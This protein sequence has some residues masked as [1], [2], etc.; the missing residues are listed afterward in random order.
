MSSNASLNFL[1]GAAS[2]I[3]N[4][5]WLASVNGVTIFLGVLLSAMV[6]NTHNRCDE[7][8]FN[9]DNMVYFQYVVAIILLV[10]FLL[11]FVIDMAAVV[12]RG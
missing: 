7:P 1:G 11:L 4:Y 12:R 3:R 10:V 2:N 5:G 8:G 9:N 6:I